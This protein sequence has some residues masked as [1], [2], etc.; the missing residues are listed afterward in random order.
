MAD[1]DI[2]KLTQAIAEYREWINSEEHVRRGRVGQAH[3]QILLDFVLFATQQNLAWE[4]MFTATTLAA[5]G[6]QNVSDNA[7]RALQALGTFLY[8]Q[9]KIKR[10][11]EIS[12]PQKALPEI[13]EQ[14]LRYFAEACEPSSSHQRNV[15][16]L[17]SDLH[18]YLSA[19]GIDLPQMGIEDLDAFLNRYKVAENTR[20]LYRYC[21]RGFLKYLYFERGILKRDLAGLLVGP[22]QFAP[23][24]LP[25]FLR[26]EQI[27]ELLDSLTLDTAAG[28]R[29]AAMVHL[30][31]FLG[32]RPV[33]ISRI[34]LDD[35]GFDNAELRIPERKTQNPITLPLPPQTLQLM[36]LYL[37]QARPKSPFRELFLSQCFPYPPAPAHIVVGCISRAMKKAGL[38]G[39]AYWLRHTYAQCLLHSHCSIFEIKEMLGHQNL[40]SSHRYVHI[41][42]SLMRTVLFDE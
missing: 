42:I 27:R 17:L 4:D 32:L 9:G 18:A 34:R 6:R 3:A 11:M 28:I 35:I 7:P 33:E 31:L 19:H 1:P 39:S 21:V 13:Y 30:A 16:R 24:K 26:P 38:P 25:K 10:P 41:H 40:Q 5:F 15:H 8:S 36:E 12:K 14:Y 29:T 22:P 23:R 2:G 20:R 37:R